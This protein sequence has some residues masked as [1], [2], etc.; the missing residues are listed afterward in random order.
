MSHSPP[1]LP[2][3][4]GFL[5]AGP[6][7]HPT[8]TIAGIPLDI[9]TTNRARRLA[10]TFGHPPCQ[11]HADG[12]RPSDLGRRS[13]GAPDQISVIF[14]RAGDIPASLKVIEEQATSDRPP[15]CACVAIMVPGA[16]RALR[17]RLGLLA[18]VHFDAHVDT[19]LDNFGQFM[20]MAPSSITRSMRNWSIPAGRSRSN[21]LLVQREVIACGRA[22]RAS[23]SSAPRT[24]MSLVR[25]RLPVRGR[26]SATPP[27]YLSFDI[28]VLDPGLRPA[29]KP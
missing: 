9:G 21:W 3:Q 5:G 26:L 16:A 11:P 2:F 28:D 8:I 1:T 24:S 22:S 15:G 4:L 6:F 10:S 14:A 13:S 19:R 17:Q 7:D 29:L 20:L 25:R 12:R 23:A 27:G 18:F